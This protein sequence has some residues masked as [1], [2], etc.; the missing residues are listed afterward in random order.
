MKINL[1]TVTGHNTTMLPHMIS[2]YQDLVDEI[3][4]IAYLQNEKDP[5]LEEIKSYGITPHRIVV[6]KQFNWERVTEL[7]NETKLE[8]PDEWWI[9][10]DDDELHLYPKHPREI[11]QECEENG[12]EFVTGGFLDRIGKNGTL[13]EINPE[14]DIWKEFPLAG[15]FR[16]PIS[17]ACPNKVC[18]MKGKV[19][20]SNGQH[21]VLFNNKTVWGVEGTKHRKR[22]PVSKGLVQVHH[23][24]WDN[25]VI[26]RLRQVSTVEEEYSYWQ[27]Y[28]RMYDYFSGS[29]NKVDISTKGF[30]I[31]RSGNSYKD[32]K[33]WK[34]VT[35]KIIKI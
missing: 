26:D 34:T 4:V 7:Y 23:F 12:W 22:Y 33:M 21:Y 28:K 29:K 10:A 13:P 3:Y 18:L 17:G 19:K 31:T 25:T 30:Y 16:Y 2:Y 5:V 27:E 8:K 11:I 15:F 20:V 6:D 24:K 1:V 35:N 14:S 9:V 32:Y